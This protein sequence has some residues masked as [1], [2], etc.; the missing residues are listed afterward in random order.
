MTD[1]RRD[2]QTPGENNMFPSPKGRRHNFLLIHCSRI[3]VF[4]VHVDI[5]SQIRPA[6]HRDMDANGIR[7]GSYL[8]IKINLC[9][10]Y[11]AHTTI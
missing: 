11:F 1:R 2:G 9:V 3:T 8:K 6:Y 10:M 7:P 5:L 4:H